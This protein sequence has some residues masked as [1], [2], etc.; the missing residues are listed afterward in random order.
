M[1]KLAKEFADIINEQD[2]CFDHYE[3]KVIRLAIRAINKWEEQNKGCYG[4]LHLGDKKYK[5]ESCARVGHV[6]YYVSN[7]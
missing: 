5:C 6:D 1:G 2:F 7:G 4:C 3:M